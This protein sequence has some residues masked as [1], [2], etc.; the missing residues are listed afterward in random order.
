[1]AEDSDYRH[2]PTPPTIPISK[3]IVTIPEKDLRSLKD[4]LRTSKLGPRTYENTGA[5][6]KYGVTYEWMSQAKDYWESTFDWRGVEST[7]NSI[8]NFMAD[9]SIPIASTSQ[10]NSFQIHF[11]ALFSQ[12]KDAI[13]LM[14]IHGWP[15]SFLEFLGILSAL[16]NKYSPVDLPYH[17]IV[18][19]LPGYAFSGTPPLDRDWRLEDSANL[20][21]KLMCGLGFEAGY[22]LQGGDIGSYT[23]RIMAGT[24]NSCKALH[25][26]FCPIP[27]PDEKVHG[28]LPIQEWEK[29]G[30]ERA[31]DFVKYGTAYAVEQSTRAS[32][33][34][35]VLSS[36]PVALLAW[37]GEK[38]LAWTDETP[39]LDQILESVTLYWLTETIPRAMYPYRQV[40]A[41]RYMP[42]NDPKYHCRQPL[43]YSWFPKEIVPIPQSWASTTGNLVWSN[44]HTKG[45]HFAAMEQPQELLA[46]IED[47]L[48]QVWLTGK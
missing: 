17:I 3:F 37:I 40:C 7:I 27:C 5:D 46:D 36:S 48:T 6:G 42:H 14:C 16:Q 13:P 28:R 21:H 24:F 35:F 33:I 12:R 22:A 1:M 39:S 29:R 9:I 10:D 15:G 38:F 45:G 20:L 11:A 8:P 32:T 23:A 44:K 19:S 4:Q 31:D 41:Q 47:F 18:P 34:G 26:N 2:F 43:G 30:L 25:L